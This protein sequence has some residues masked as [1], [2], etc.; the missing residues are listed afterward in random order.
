MI[1]WQKVPSVTSGGKKYFWTAQTPRGR[2]WVIYDRHLKK[3]VIQ[4]EGSTRPVQ[5]FG[6]PESSKKFVKAWIQERNPMKFLRKPKKSLTIKRKRG[7][8]NPFDLKVGIGKLRSEYGKLSTFPISH[9][10]R[11]RAMFSKADDETIKILADA[12]IKFVSVMAR[13]EIFR[14]GLIKNRC[15]PKMWQCKRCNH[16]FL[17]KD[18]VYNIRTKG[19]V[20]Y[21]CDSILSKRKL[22]RNPVHKPVIIYD[23]LLEI[24]AVKKHG[25]FKGESFKHNFRKDTDA[26]VLGLKDG[27]LKIV[28]RVGKPLW[29]KFNY[30]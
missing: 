10:E 23:R 21:D 8:I 22:K 29:R 24:S 9:Y 25:K 3:W 2:V 13:N 19:N 28:S 30:D 4:V 12:K 18:L 27:S 20:C 26:V 1:K 15:N 17:P 14:R 11:F 16:K 5:T 6:S 7:L